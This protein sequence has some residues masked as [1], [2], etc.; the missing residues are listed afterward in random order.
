MPTSRSQ[1]RQGV[2]GILSSSILA[3]LTAGLLNGIASAA[4]S[5]QSIDQRG[6][7]STPIDASSDREFG[8]ALDWLNRIDKDRA[9][10]REK[11]VLEGAFRGLEPPRQRRVGL[12]PRLTL[13]TDFTDN[14]FLASTPSARESDLTFSIAPGLSYED[15]GPGWSL[16]ADYSFESAAYSNHEYLNEVLDAQQARL[17]GNLLLSPLTVVGFFNLYRE[18]RDAEEQVL[19][20]PNPNL[21]RY[22]ANELVAYGSHNF[23]P[24]VS[25]E[26]IYRNQLQITDEPGSSDILMNEGLATLRIRTTRRDRLTLRLGQRDFD[27]SPG[28]DQ[29]VQSGTLGFEHEFSQRFI[30]SVTGGWLRSSTRNGEDFLQASGELQYSTKQSVTTLNATRNI[31]TTPGFDALLLENAI[32]GSIVYRVGAGVRASLDVSLAEYETLNS[33]R[34]IIDSVEITPS[35]S[36]AF[37]NGQWLVLKYGY[38]HQSIDQG[39]SI[40]SNRVTLGFVKSFR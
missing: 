26:I 5:D 37:D 28:I 38:R 6:Q 33:A 31:T 12:E 3:L 15:A 40:T 23:S 29:E 2:P 13:T 14:L 8:S 25:A 34:L 9:P 7:F 30:A 39:P 24:T 22:K 36:Y 11:P 21:T 4:S 17:S 20:I 32:N 18:T 35:L 16:L 19:L 1:A 27:F 10:Q